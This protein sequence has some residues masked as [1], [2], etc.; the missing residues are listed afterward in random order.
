MARWF[1][2]DENTAPIAPQSWSRG[3]CGNG[4][5]VSSTTLRLV[6]GDDGAPVLGAKVGVERIALA[7][8]ILLEDVL[9]IVDVDVEHD[10]RVHLNEAAIGVVGEARVVRRLRQ[11]FDRGVVQPEVEDRV[12][13]ARHRGAR[14]RPHRDEQRIGRVAEGAP[15]QAADLGDR[16]VDLRRKI[17]RIGLAVGVEVGADFGGDGEARRH[18]QAERGH[19]VQVRALAA[20]QVL[21]LRPAFGA[22]GAE[23]VDPLRHRSAPQYPAKDLGALRSARATPCRNS[24]IRPRETGGRRRAGCPKHKRCR[25][26][27]D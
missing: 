19:L 2:Q 5:P 18:G 22:L 27:S 10:V 15:G 14:A 24:P 12:H 1:I 16:C 7:F 23:G 20:E 13:H 26:A 6:V 11:S 4:L 17:R 3:A 8:L 9:E 25:A 21:H